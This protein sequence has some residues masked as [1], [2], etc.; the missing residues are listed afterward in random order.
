MILRRLPS[1]RW[2]VDSCNDIAGGRRRLTFGTKA[3]AEKQLADFAAQ[4]D[5]YGK[6]TVLD[7]LEQKAAALAFAS[8]KAKGFNAPSHLVEAAGFFI[9]NHATT[10]ATLDKVAG[11]FL[12]FKR[13]QEEAGELRHAYVKPMKNMLKPVTEKFGAR[14]FAS[15]RRPEL[16]LF[17]NN[18]PGPPYSRHAYFRYA[19]MLWR[20][21]ETME[22][23][24]LNP[25][26]KIKA[27]TLN[28]LTPT[29]L[30]VPQAVSLVETAAKSHR[31]YLPYVTLAL[32][33]GLRSAEL[34]RLRWEHINQ[35]E[36]TVN[37]S[38]EVAKR[39]FYR[40]V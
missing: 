33:V 32:F 2:L 40:S 22:L 9:S 30:T 28:P 10:T 17:F 24:Q 29:V 11:D 39:L 4:K 21:A 35:A 13:R 36:M 1:G 31:H 18:L 34:Q 14:E 23:I 26:D 20:W 38:A 3:E 5:M 6:E 27:P 15:I 25:F 16:I 19:R 7:P 37:V 12:A 8:L